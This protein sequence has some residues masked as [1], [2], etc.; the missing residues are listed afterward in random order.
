MLEIETV[1][2]LSWDWV[3]RERP[4][5]AGQ[6]GAGSWVPWISLIFSRTWGDGGLVLQQGWLFL[7]AWGKGRAPVGQGI[8]RM[9][10]INPLSHLIAG[11]RERSVLRDSK[12]SH[13]PLLPPDPALGSGDVATLSSCQ[14]G[15]RGQSSGSSPGN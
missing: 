14:A 15:Q 13:I 2:A 1:P 11:H 7:M 9:E 10:N 4:T 3:G 6:G 5:G 8:V 12:A